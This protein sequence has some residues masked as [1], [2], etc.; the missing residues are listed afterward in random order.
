M[1]VSRSKLKAGDSSDTVLSIVFCLLSYTPSYEQH[2]SIL[3][4]FISNINLERTVHPFAQYS[5][6]GQVRA[7]DVRERSPEP[8][9]SAEGY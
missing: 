7:E 3:Y 4:I 1:I 2:L 6:P 9:G 5:S 8:Q